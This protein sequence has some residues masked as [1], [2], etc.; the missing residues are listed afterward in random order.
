MTQLRWSTPTAP[1]LA[2]LEESI[3]AG[4]YYSDGRVSGAPTRTSPSSIRDGDESSRSI[5]T[6]NIDDREKH[7]IHVNSTSSLFPP[8]AVVNVPTQ[9]KSHPDSD[10][11]ADGTSVASE[12]QF[13]PEDYDFHTEF[14]E[15]RPPSEQQLIDASSMEL[16]DEDG[17]TVRF[18]DLYPTAPDDLDTLTPTSV[19]EPP[20]DEQLQPKT[21]FFFIRLLACGQCQDYMTASVARLSPDVIAAH[22]VRVVII[23]N[24]SWRGIKRYRQIMK[25]SFPMY[26]DPTLDLYRHLE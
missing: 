4:V 18:G 14:D 5:E 17:N 13:A 9:P 20:A 2:R 8:V 6:S 24:G 21:V 15:Y 7:D 23:S 25:C 19:G 22:K 26:V 11:P 1:E 3:R 12:Q 10:L 16:L